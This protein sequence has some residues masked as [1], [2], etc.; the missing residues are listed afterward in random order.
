VNHVRKADLVGFSRRVTVRRFQRYMNSDLIGVAGLGFLGR[1]I[2]TSLL[3]HGFRVIGYTVGADTHERARDYAS[4]GIQELITRA[5]F[6][7]ALEHEWPER[8]VVA[9]SL[10]DFASCSFVIESVVED[11]DIKQEV[12]NELEAAVGTTVPIASNTSAIPITLLQSRRNHP[13]RFL[14][15]H[16]AEPAYATRFLELIRGEQTSDAAMASAEV[17]ARRTGKDACVVQR[18]VTGF[19]A[20][21][22]GYALYREAIDLWESGVADIDTIDRAFRN[23]CGLWAALC[24]PF[25]WIDITGGPA[26]YAKGMQRIWPTLSNRADLPASIQKMQ[27]EGNRGV[28]DGNGFYPYKPG[29]AAQW[30]ALLHQHAW[31]VFRLQERSDPPDNSKEKANS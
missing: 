1:G 14:G 17:L 9:Q 27:A 16:W 15:M 26:L 23:A 28:M 12:F 3:A 29:D 6:P 7:A 2:A 25:R 24:G 22:L 31:E 20:N 13:E 21:R 8:Y 11:F 30:E 10:A 5:G 19:I 18:D 4:K